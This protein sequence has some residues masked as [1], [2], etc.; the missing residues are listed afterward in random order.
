MAVLTLSP[1]A[2]PYSSGNGMPIR[3]NSPILR[4]VSAGNS[5]VS[6]TRRARGAISFSANSRTAWRSMRCSSDSSKSTLYPP[7]W[8]HRQR[9][10]GV[11]IPYLFTNLARNVR[12]KVRFRRARLPKLP[13]SESS[14]PEQPDRVIGRAALG[15]VGQDAADQHAEL[16]AVTRAGR[17]DHDLRVNRVAID[18]E[19]TVGG[20]GIAAGLG[21][22]HF[23]GGLG[24]QPRDVITQGIEPFRDERAVVAV[25][26]DGRA[27]TVPRDLDAWQAEDREAV[28]G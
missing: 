11:S 9:S 14:Q 20:T 22:D 25:W 8:H 5:P 23:A 10:P 17:P 2:P 12:R 13:T 26:L 21:I 1:P 24:E 15:Q 16:E 7:R 6:S 3:P 18:D 19:V 27:A 28:A 4:N